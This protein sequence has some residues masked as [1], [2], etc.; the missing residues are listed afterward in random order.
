MSNG[1]LVQA[2]RPNLKTV[3]L[4]TV[5][6]MVAGAVPSIALAQQAAS[7]PAADGTVS[8]VVITG[9]RRSLAEARALKRDATIQIDAIVAE[10]MAKFPELN[11]AESLQRLRRRVYSPL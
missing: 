1:I 2:A 10:D 6:A 7:P 3:L 4:A 11:L 5:S 8:E 9:Y